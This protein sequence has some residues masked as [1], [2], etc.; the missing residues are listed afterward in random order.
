MNSI[1]YYI[2]TILSLL[3]IYSCD[4][5]EKKR[6]EAQM[7]IEQE[8]QDSIRRDSLSFC[9]WEDAKFGMSKEEI[10]KTEAF[11]NVKD[12]GENRLLL[13]YFD[14]NDIKTR[15][16]LS[17]LANVSLSF[18]SKGFY[19]IK[20]SSSNSVTADHIDDMEEDC[21]RII[22][23]IEEGFGEKL[24]WRYKDLSVFDFN[25]GKNIN[26]L[27]VKFG[28][29]LIL[30]TMGEDYNNPTYWYNVTATN[31]KLYQ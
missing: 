10:L 19:Q 1:K 20:F 16:K 2:F 30:V 7:R 14:V 24:P 11:K 4:N 31:I 12:Y 23:I 28:N 15:L 29:T 27:D 22:E 13:S 5:S 17:E 18:N 6:Q 9:I 26:I 21:H 25:E 8:K 3:A